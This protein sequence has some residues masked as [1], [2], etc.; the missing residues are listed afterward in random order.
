MRRVDVELGLAR[1][2]G[3]RT[4]DIAHLVHNRDSRVTS[5]PL[6]ALRMRLSDS[7]LPPWAVTA[8]GR[9][10]IARGAVPRRTATDPIDH[11]MGLRPSSRKLSMRSE[12]GSVTH[13]SA[14]ARASGQSRG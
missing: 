12:S 5:P 3:R 8:P 10:A 1:I 6:N 7:I 2:R 4:D 14:D 11:R 9:D 13:S